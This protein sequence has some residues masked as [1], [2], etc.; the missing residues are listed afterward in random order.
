[1]REKG[2]AEYSLLTRGT[3]MNVSA[4]LSNVNLAPPKKK[5]VLKAD[6]KY[7]V[8]GRSIYHKITLVGKRAFV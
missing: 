8:P 6:T 4:Q 3:A 5:V 1:M 7:G 2:R